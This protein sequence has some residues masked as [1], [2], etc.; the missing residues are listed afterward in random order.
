VGKVVVDI[1]EVQLEKHLI[2]LRG[3]WVKVANNWTPVIVVMTFKL[4]R[5]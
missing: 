5:G 1:C 4:M 3:E 2:A